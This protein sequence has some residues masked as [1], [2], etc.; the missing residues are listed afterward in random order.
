MRLTLLL[1]S[2]LALN[3]SSETYYIDDLVIQASSDTSS[4]SCFTGGKHSILVTGSIAPTVPLRG[5][6]IDQREPC[7]D[8]DGEVICPIEVTLESGGGYLDDGYN[9]GEVFRDRAVTTIIPDNM[10][11]ASLCAVAFL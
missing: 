6:L 5:K 3:V 7:L 1:T 4:A 10:M 8:A 2:F 11:C 9:L